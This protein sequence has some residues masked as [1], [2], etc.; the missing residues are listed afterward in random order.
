MTETDDHRW[1]LR[2]SRQGYL[3][4]SGEAFDKKFEEWAERD[5]PEWL[6][7]KLAFPFAVTREEDGR[8]VRA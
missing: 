4:A 2:E 6:A 5:W 1:D 3:P 7:Q 8:L